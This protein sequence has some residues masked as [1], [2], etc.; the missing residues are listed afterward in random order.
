MCALENGHVTRHE[1]SL[2]PGNGNAKQRTQQRGSRL[3]VSSVLF[4]W[5]FPPSFASA[6]KVGVVG[7]VG[8]S[9]EGVS[10]PM[11]FPCGSLAMQSLLV[12]E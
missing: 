8:A 12:E 11:A 10:I 5:G 6:G 7:T 9:P 4:S 3:L 2:F 1:Y